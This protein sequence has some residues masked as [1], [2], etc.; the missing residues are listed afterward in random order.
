D[1]HRACGVRLEPEET[2]RHG[3]L[4]PACGK[5]LT[6]GVMHRVDELADRPDGAKREKRTPFR[7]LVPLPEVLAEIHRVGAGSRKVADAYEN[8]VGRSEERRVGKES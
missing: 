4:C 2:N 5:G 1:G 7:S 3:G 6:V 8:L